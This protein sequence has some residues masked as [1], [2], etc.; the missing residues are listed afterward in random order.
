MSLVVHR[1][2]GQIHLHAQSAAIGPLAQQ[3]L[4]ARRESDVPT[5]RGDAAVVHDIFRDEI[6]LAALS[7]LNF[8]EIDDAGQRRR[9]VECP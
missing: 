6:S 8:P 4:L 3:H 1:T 7:D 9:A 5:G 2:V